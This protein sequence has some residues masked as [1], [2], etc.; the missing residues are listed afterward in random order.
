MLFDNLGLAGGVVILF[1]RLLS[2]NLFGGIAGGICF[3]AGGIFGDAGGVASTEA[4]GD[5]CT[6]LKNLKKL[7][8]Q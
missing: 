4:A 3:C 8:V 7:L 2:R 6:G 1:G 5:I